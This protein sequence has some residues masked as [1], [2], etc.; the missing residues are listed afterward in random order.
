M[1]LGQQQLDVYRLSIGYIAWVYDTQ[2][3]KDST[4]YGYTDFDFDNDFDFDE[5]GSS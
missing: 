5:K 1:A 2:L 4:L 3:R